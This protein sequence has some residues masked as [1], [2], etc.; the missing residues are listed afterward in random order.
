MSDDI[1]GTLP[2]K[3]WKMP[4]GFIFLCAACNLWLMD[5]LVMIT[6]SVIPNFHVVRRYRQMF[7]LAEDH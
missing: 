7:M 3:H 4:W 6:F 5:P 2:N 1:A